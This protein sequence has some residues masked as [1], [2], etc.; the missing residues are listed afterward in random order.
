MKRVLLHTIKPEGVGGTR[1]VVN[2]I[3]NSY[4]KEKYEFIDLVQEEV[5][6]GSIIKAISFVRKYKRIIDASKADAIYV[7]GLLYSGFLITLS[8]KLSS[9]KRIVVSVHG[10]ELDKTNQNRIKQWIFGHFIEPLTVYMAD[11]VFTVCEKELSNPVIRRGNRGNVRGAIY[12]MIPSVNEEDYQRGLFRLSIGCPES[13]VLVAV[14]G[15]VVEDK[16]HEYIIDAINQLQS[17]DF[18]FVIVGDGPY[19]KEYHIKCKELIEK[20]QLF[21]LGTRNDV[22]QI[23]KDSD[24][25]L[26]AT[27]H[28]NHSKSLLEAVKMKCAVI[29]TDVG[30]NPEIIDSNTGILIPPKDSGAIISSL[31]RFR[32]KETRDSYARRAYTVVTEKFSEIN[33]MGKLDVLFS[34]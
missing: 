2:D 13:K 27:L 19:L 30:G 1:T 16:G 34:K 4:L 12:N 3:K 22:F 24:V 20:R 29:C 18:V 5:C 26:F 11:D 31:W 17:E 14:V 6:G 21:V 32:D 23:L 7:C 10:S 33:T 28:E 25:F 15:R 9:V 8:A